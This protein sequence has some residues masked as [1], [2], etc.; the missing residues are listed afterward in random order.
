MF[1][2]ITYPHVHMIRIF[3]IFVLILLFHFNL[4]HSSLI[5]ELIDVIVCQGVFNLHLLILSHSCNIW[6][7]FL[8]KL[9]FIFIRGYFLINFNFLTL[10]ILLRTLFTIVTKFCKLIIIDASFGRIEL[11]LIIMIAKGV[12]EIIA[13]INYGCTESQHTLT[14][15]SLFNIFHDFNVF[16]IIFII[17]FLLYLLNRHTWCH[18]TIYLINFFENFLEFHFIIKHNSTEWLGHRSRGFSSYHVLFKK[19]CSFFPMNIYVLSWLARCPINFRLRWNCFL[20]QSIPPSFFQWRHQIFS[21]FNFLYNSFYHFIIY[22]IV[23]FDGSVRRH[24]VASEWYILYALI[25]VPNVY[26]YLE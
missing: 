2:W 8:N 11:H 15:G 10:I 5:V 20:Q 12:G 25:Q 3:R 7:I 13:V 14:W 24:H 9:I 6:I 16:V 22:I 18:F 1:G 26:E 19:V 21:Q 17:Y 4:L 23:Q